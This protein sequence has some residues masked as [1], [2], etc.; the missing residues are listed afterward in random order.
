MSLGCLVALTV[1]TALMAAGCTGLAERVSDR[2]KYKPVA[3]SPNG[4]VNPLRTQQSLQPKSASQ[5]VSGKMPTTAPQSASTFRPIQPSDP[6][7]RAKQVENVL[8]VGRNDPFAPSVSRILPAATTNPGIVSSPSLLMP[9][10]PGSPVPLSSTLPQLPS[11]IPAQLPPVVVSVPALPPTAIAPPMPVAQL[12]TL[13]PSTPTSSHSVPV[14]P[15]STVSQVPTA[16]VSLARAIQVMGVVQTKGKA[17]AI[18]EVP[19][20][21]TPRSVYVGDRLGNGTVLVKRIQTNG[22]QEPIVILEERGQ[23]IIRSVGSATVF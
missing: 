6:A 3:T 23:E 12:P 20:E 16:P 15:P 4:S 18:I 9:T 5:S 19:G 2:S 11:Q 7:Q 17:S 10:V 1:G 8:Q 22:S 13:P 21:G 14:S